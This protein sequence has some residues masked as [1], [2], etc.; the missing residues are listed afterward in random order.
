MSWAIAAL[1][2]K[3]PVII[4][5]AEAV[6]KSYPDFWQDYQQLGGKFDVL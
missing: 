6:A 1:V 4:R 2:A 5:G 3:A